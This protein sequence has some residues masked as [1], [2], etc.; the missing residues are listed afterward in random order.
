MEALPAPPT[1]LPSPTASPAASGR[2]YTPPGPPPRV[3]TGSATVPLDSV[4]F[5]TFRGGFIPLPEASEDV[6]ESL[7][8][9]IRPI[10]KP[11][12]ESVEGGD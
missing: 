2:P 6:I 3:D 10:D 8:D 4:V 7:R 11:A 12:Y 9:A 1:T 5:D